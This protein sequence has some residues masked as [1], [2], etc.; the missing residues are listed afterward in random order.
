MG[1]NLI[2]QPPEWRPD[3]TTSLLIRL[4]F[5][6]PTNHGSIPWR[7]ERYSSSQRHPLSFLFSEYHRICLLGRKLTTQHP[8]LLRLRNSEVLP[9]LI[10]IFRHVIHRDYFLLNMKQVWQHSVISHCMRHDRFFAIWVECERQMLRITLSYSGIYLH[11]L[12]KNS[13]FQAFSICA[14]WIQKREQIQEATIKQYAL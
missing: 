3:S 9:L 12:K 4:P 6:H 13:E 7:S 11:V 1:W 2:L 14:L 5:R 8:L 10:Y